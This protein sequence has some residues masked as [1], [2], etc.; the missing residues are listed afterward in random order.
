MNTS[1][2][3]SKLDLHFGMFGVQKFS[4]SAPRF[5]TLVEEVFTNNVASLGGRGYLPNDHFTL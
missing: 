5:K 3:S 1:F 4:I 2:E